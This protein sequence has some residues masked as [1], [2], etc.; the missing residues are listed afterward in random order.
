MAKGAFDKYIEF[1]HEYLTAVHESISELIG[2]GPRGSH[3][4]LSAKL[5]SVRRKYALWVTSETDQKLSQFE[6]AIWRMAVSA[7]LTEATQSREQ[8]WK[9]QYQ[10]NKGDGGN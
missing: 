5:S 4:A 9:E 6:D 7:G 3:L 2:S 8:D 10:S 1:A